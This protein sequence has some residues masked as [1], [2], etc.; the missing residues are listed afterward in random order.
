MTPA[1]FTPVPIPVVADMSL[2]LLF[3]YPKRARRMPF[4]R[5]SMKD[6]Y[7]PFLRDEEEIRPV[8]SPFSAEAYMAH[9][10]FSRGFTLIEIISVLV[11]LG[12]L[13]AVAVPK[14]Y[15]LQ[16]ESEKKAA[17]SAV[18]EAQSRINLAFGQQL[19]Q[20]KPCEEAVE[21]VASIQQI[22]DNGQGAQFGDFFLGTDPA[23]SGG[24]LVDGGNLIYARRS[25]SGEIVDTGAKLYLPSCGEASSGLAS[26]FPETVLGYLDKVLSENSHDFRKDILGQ[27]VSLGNGVD[28]TVTNIVN[29]GGNKA[30]IDFQYTNGA[31]DALS[32]QVHKARDGSM[33]IQQ[34]IVRPKNGSSINLI[35]DNY[36]PNLNEAQI[37]QAKDIVSSMGLNTNDFGSAFSKDFGNGIVKF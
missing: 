32:F 18:A 15:D 26:N 14:Y 31:G 23:A 8:H 33:W 1:R 2:P 11:I 19:L 17:L 10:R 21:Q 9:P 35:K 13:A 30:Y 37:G 22:S 16:Q 6:S 7:C 3:F 25:E 28:Y 5:L 36:R 27:T 24:T 4:F 34:M 20:G 29:Q 12:I